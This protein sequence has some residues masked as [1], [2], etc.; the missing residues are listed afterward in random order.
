MTHAKKCLE[1]VEHMEPEYFV[2]LGK[3]IFNSSVAIVPRLAPQESEIVLTE[4]LTRVKNSGAWPEAPLL[5]LLPSLAGKSLEIIENRD[6]QK[7]LNHCYQQT[8][9]DLQ[10]LVKARLQILQANFWLLMLNKSHSS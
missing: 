6:V 3:T 1:R 7:C 9:I 5:A 10:K 2:G 4:R 8:K